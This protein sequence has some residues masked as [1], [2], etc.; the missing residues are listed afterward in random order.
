M[1]FF[2]TILA[3]PWG[4]VLV[5]ILS[6]VN[7]TIMTMRTIMAVRGRRL[8]AA[9]L[10][11]FQMLVWLLAVGGALQHLDSVLHVLGYAG[12]YALGNYVGVALEQRLAIGTSI[13]RAVSTRE[14]D[15]SGESKVASHLRERDFAVTEVPARSWRGD[16]HVLNVVVPRKKV[17]EV[18]ET[19]EQA[20]ADAS[21]SVEE[22]Q[23]TRGGFPE[24]ASRA[25]RPPWPWRRAA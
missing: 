17:K 4:A 24:G 16:V 20:D 8:P 19:V 21:I 13:V 9:F 22:I 12:G 15:A 14:Q 10:G 25:T 23:A 6:A 11:F 1:Q 5:F 2:E 7:V 3:S 18:V